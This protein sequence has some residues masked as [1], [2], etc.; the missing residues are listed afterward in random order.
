MG[1]AAVEREEGEPTSVRAGEEA[2]DRREE[3]D[4]AVEEEGDAV[5]RRADGKGRLG[6]IGI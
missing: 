4:V 3:G 2:E 6:M 5:G 1:E